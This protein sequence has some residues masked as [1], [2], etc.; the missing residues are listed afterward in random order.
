MSATAASVAITAIQNPA[1]VSIIDRGG[2]DAAPH[3][4]ESR[5]SGVT[6][7]GHLLS[8]PRNRH[9]EGRFPSRVLSGRGW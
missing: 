5:G 6:T 7:I 9:R 8:F 2:A 1:A 3:G 4:T